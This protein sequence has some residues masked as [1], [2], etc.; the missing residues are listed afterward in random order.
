M[1]F[2]AVLM[3]I[4]AS[5]A[6]ASAEWIPLAA[7]G[8]PQAYTAKVLNE[9]PQSMVVELRFFGFSV[10]TV[11]TEAGDFQLLSLPPSATALTGSIGEPALPSVMDVIALPD[12]AVP[13]VEMIEAE[14]TDVGKFR[15]YPLQKPQRDDGPTDNAFEFNQ[16]VYDQTN[17][18]PPDN[19]ALSPAQGWGGLAVTGLTFIPFR[20]SPRDG[21]LAM[22][23]RAIIRIDFQPSPRSFVKSHRP[24]PNLAR[25]QRSVI[26]NYP[27]FRPFDFDE[28]E[29]V[30]LLVV[31]KQE[32]LEA[33]QPLIDYHQATGLRMDVFIADDLEGPEE[34]KEVVGERYEEG[35]EYLFLIG[36]GD[37]FQWDVPMYYW[38]PEDPGTY[39]PDT[40]SH[41]DT[42][43][44]CQDGLNQDGFEDCIPDLSVG[45]LT[46]EDPEHLDQLQL[47]VAK[48]LDY[49]LWRFDDPDNAGWLGRAVLVTSSASLPNLGQE[50]L[51]CA[52]NI[53]QFNYSQPCPE[54]IPYFGDDAN[55]TINNLVALVNG[56][57]VGIFNY[58][59]HGNAIYMNEAL[60]GRS[61]N[62]GIVRQMNNRQTPFILVSSACL[63]ANLATR[64]ADCILENFQ[65]REGG[66][67]GAHGSV[68]STFTEGNSYF[69][70]QLFQA[71][72]DQGIPDLGYAVNAAMTQMVLQ[73]DTPLEQYRVIG[74]MNARAYIWLADPAVQYRLQRPAELT[75]DLPDTI[76]VATRFLNGAVR[77]DGQAVEGAAVCI[78]KRD[79]SVYQVA[80]TDENGGY[81]I[82]FE[83][84]LAEAGMLQWAVTYREGIPLFGEMAAADGLGAAQGV[85]SDLSNGEPIEG[86]LI[87]FEPFN[88]EVVSDVHGHFIAERIPEAS[89]TLTTSAPGF[90]TER[91]EGVEVVNND[92]TEV[93]I[94]LRFCQLAVGQ[95]QI[96]Q[97]LAP[98]ARNV[99][100]L[101]LQNIGNAPLSWQAQIEPA[102]E[103]EQYELFTSIEIAEALGDRRLNGIVFA[104]DRFYVTGGHDNDEPNYIY[105]L[106]R[107]GAP[108]PGAR[109]LQPGSAGIGMHDLAWDGECLYGSSTASIYRMSV[110]GQVLSTFDGP[111]NPN[112]ALAI[113]DDGTLWAANNRS[114]LVNI[115]LQGNQLGEIP[116]VLP[117]RALAWDGEVLDGFNLLMYVRS[118]A[119]TPL[120]YAANPASGQIRFLADLLTEEGDIPADG[121]FVS[122]SYSTTRR[123]AMGMVNNDTFRYIR[124]WYLGPPNWV[125]SEPAGGDIDADVEAVVNLR[126]DA[127]GLTDGDRLQANLNVRNNGRTPLIV[128]PLTLTVD[129]NADVSEPKDVGIPF[130]LGIASVYPNP[131]NARTT[132]SVS[133]PA[134]EPISLS[135][136][137]LSGRLVS[138]IY[139]GV[140]PAGSHRL[141]FDGEGLASGIYLLA[142]NTPSEKHFQKIALIR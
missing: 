66:S 75:I 38:D 68:I 29:P 133:V 94:Q 117:V 67:I 107:N 47:Q 124:M 27:E 140:L 1:V 14:W 10:E 17:V 16:T 46:Y 56:D 15:I 82:D 85:V 106:D 91:V 114:A 37:S 89:Y 33:A 116:N 9:T 71:W 97:M 3:L 57:G 111:F 92:T 108:I 128:V 88:I 64:V 90:L 41:S 123:L 120:L 54:L 126:F 65:K 50:Y 83:P 19:A 51:R 11:K 24:G 70:Q 77:A 13:S 55:A 12:R 59:G 131:F 49:L 137:D 100:Y 23:S 104:D 8:T 93:N 6:L 78:Q 42:W 134:S 96:T 135:V 34:L 7:G 81:H 28:N 84:H 4:L 30:R 40:D 103:I 39:V 141:V 22:T 86:A 32:A 136:Y 121:L 119:G 26:I 102:D 48:I 125:A 79:G 129:V 63:N 5:T 127:E 2:C 132:V 98:D 76:S 35:L 61:I 109:F 99:Q 112:A 60:H 21:E 118:D 53:L 44:A 45:R 31:L 18:L 25:A 101:I 142:L 62:S 122:R 36:D 72:F 58:R 20:Y 74:R 87:L 130:E 95:A 73:Y 105:V 69:D 110:N 80:F 115:D 43:Y 113:G 139:S 52:N 138:T